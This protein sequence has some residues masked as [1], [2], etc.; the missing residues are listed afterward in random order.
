MPLRDRSA[1]G[2][3]FL[4]RVQDRRRRFDQFPTKGFRGPPVEDAEKHRSTQSGDPAEEARVVHGLD[5][6]NPGDIAIA[7]DLQR[8]QQALMGHTPRDI[9]L[10]EGAGLHLLAA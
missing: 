1:R 5:H 2:T 9:F 3:Q 6:R 4:V 10:H 8:I 7:H